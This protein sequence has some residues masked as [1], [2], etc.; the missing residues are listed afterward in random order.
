MPT[1][2]ILNLPWLY[3]TEIKG[4]AEGCAIAEWV[5]ETRGGPRII[6]LLED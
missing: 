5:T 6:P 1:A 4:T 2:V 3:V